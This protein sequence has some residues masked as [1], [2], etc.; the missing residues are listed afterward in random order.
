MNHTRFPS[1]VSKTWNWN[2]KVMSK[3]RSCR[4]G[5]EISRI[6]TIL[7]DKIHIVICGLTV[8]EK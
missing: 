6:E 8:D 5:W 2:R 3:N 1:W 4:H 7:V